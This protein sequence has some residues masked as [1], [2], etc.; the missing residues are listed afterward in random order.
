MNFRVSESQILV[1]LQRQV[2]RETN[3][4]SMLWWPMPPEKLEVE[5]TVNLDGKTVKKSNLFL[6][7]GFWG[8]VRHPQYVFELGV[9]LSRT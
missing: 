3:G 9:A 5:Y 6:V 2:F 7:N 4:E 1:H 8:V